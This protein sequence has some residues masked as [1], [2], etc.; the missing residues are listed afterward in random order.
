[1]W[2]VTMT[3]DLG[4]IAV[5]GAIVALLIDRVLAALRDR[6]ID[7][8]RMSQQIN[9][10]Y[11]MHASRNSNGVYRWYVREELYRDVRDT[12][13]AVKELKHDLELLRL[14]VQHLKGGS[15]PKDELWPD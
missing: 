2:M 10:L 15:G 11:Q 13:E 7:L 8:R 1:M 9:E 12:K 3:I 14:E 6:G 5:I 4:Q